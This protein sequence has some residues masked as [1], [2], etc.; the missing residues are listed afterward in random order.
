MMMGSMNRVTL[1]GNVGRDP[2]V[3]YTTS[4][5]DAVNA[6]VNVSLATTESWKNK[7]GAREDK[8]EWHRLVFF[9]KVAEIAAKYVVKGKQI[10]VEGSLQTRKWT[11]KDGVDQYTTEIKVD[12]LV[13]LGGGQDS[14]ASPA[15]PTKPSRPSPVQQASAD[16]DEEIPF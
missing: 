2:D 15:R 8:T 10:L 3:R 11:N 6:I 4:V 16:L 1:L 5:D 13:L 9:G 12:K 14:A 7:A